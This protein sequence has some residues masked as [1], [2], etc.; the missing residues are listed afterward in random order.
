MGSLSQMPIAVWFV[1]VI[2]L[3]FVLVYGIMRNRTRT[4]AEKNISQRATK[5][6][7]RREDAAEKAKL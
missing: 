2:I 6:L 7:Y 1:G 3:G 5:D 4:Q